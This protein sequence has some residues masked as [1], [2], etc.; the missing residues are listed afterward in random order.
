MCCNGCS[1]SVTFYI[2]E[3][4]QMTGKERYK[5]V[6]SRR[7]TDCVPVSPDTSNMIPCR[8]TGRPFWDIYLYHKIPLWKAYIDCARHFGFDSFVDGSMPYTV[9]DEKTGRH[10]GDF[11]DVTPRPDEER[12]E[13]IVDKNDERIITRWCTI[14]NGEHFFDDSCTVYYRDNPAMYGVSLERAK[15]PK[16]PQNP[17]P[18]EGKEKELFG[19][20][21]LKYA[22]DYVGDSGFFGVR[23]GV[24]SLINNEK[25]VFEFYD[26][27]TPFYERREY[28]LEF[29]EKRL[30]LILKQDVLPD[31]IALG[32]SGSLIY[33][34]VETFKELSLPLIKKMS[35]LCKKAGIPTH[36]HS[37]G[38]EKSLV[39][40][41]AEE[42]DV[43]IIDPL[44][45]PPM[46]DCDLKELKHL[47]GDKIVLKGNLHTTNVMLNGS[48][49][50]VIEA[51]KRAIDDAAEGGGFVLSTGDQCGRD[52]PDENI[53]AMVETAR[54]YGKY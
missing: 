40:I 11:G 48:V 47:Y 33:Q 14:K 19:T 20:E 10:Y 25:E 50:D 29:Y 28:L 31:F 1:I 41:V 22:M 43:T 8:L 24:S 34:T 23:C 51:S 13:F 17:L 46:G 7:P 49:Q 5:N 12:E 27:P 2:N 16:I 21:A 15:Q 44:E 42:T 39:K 36:I 26:D 38:P 45:I 18:V 54:T 52:T 30:E 6:L 4:V 35:A 9:V 3:V 53:F 37:C 32:V